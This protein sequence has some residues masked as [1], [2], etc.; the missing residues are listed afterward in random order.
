MQ[1][2][3]L[4]AGEVARR[5]GVTSQTV[6]NMTKA[7]RLRSQRTDQGLFLFAADDVEQLRRGA[8]GVET[9]WSVVL[10]SER[11]YSELDGWDG[12]ER[13]GWLIGPNLPDRLRVDDV[14]LEDGE[15]STSHSI[16]LGLDRAREI[17]RSLGPSHALLGEWHG[18]PPGE[19]T[20]ASEADRGVLACDGFVLGP[21]LAGPR[22]DVSRLAHRVQRGERL[23]DVAGRRA[24]DDFGRADSVSW[25]LR[26]W[27][28][29]Y[30]T[31]IRTRRCPQAP[32]RSTSSLAGVRAGQ[33]TRQHRQASSSCWRL[34]AASPAEEVRSVGG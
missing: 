2:T 16:R 23:A 30:L 13:G 28:N 18:H 34:G 4:Q 26:K 8:G 12:R 33:R 6:R 25:L 17:S 15:G 31:R 24:A 20:W 32:C 7:G 10:M 29:L 9:A 5:L 1:T 21:D 22:G 14:Y 19:S 27:R 11:L 3:W